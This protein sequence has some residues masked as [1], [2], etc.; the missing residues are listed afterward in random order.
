MKSGLAALLALAAGSLHAASTT[1][2]E[3][4]SYQDFVHGKFSGVSLDR[5]GTLS[6]APAVSSLFSSGQAV[7][8]SLAAGPN[9]V[10]YAGTGHGGIVYQISPAGQAKVLWKADQPEVFALAVNP[11]GVL[12]AATSPDGKVFR[13]EGGKAAEFFDPHAKYIWSLCFAPDGTL[14]VGTGGQGEIFRVDPLGHGEKYYSTG[15]SHVTALA[16]DSQGRLLAGSE[17]NGILYRILAKDKA[18]VLFDSPLPEIRALAQGP[19]GSIYAAAMGGS[20]SNRLGVQTPTALGATT[21]GSTPSVSVTV[22]DSAAAE[23]DGQA[24]PELKPKP[25]APAAATTAVRP[26]LNALSPIVELSGVDKSAVYRILPDNTV[27][28]LWTSKDENVYDMDLSG[29]DIL[30]ATDLQGRLYR[31]GA[32]RKNALIAETGEGEIVKLL[33][34]PA[35]LVAATADMGKIFRIGS[36]PAASGSYEAPVHDTGTVARWGRLTW[37]SSDGVGTIRFETRSGNSARPDAT[38]SDWAGAPDGALSSPN[39]RFIQW[40]VFLAR[41]ASLDGV[42]LAYLPQNTPPV[43]RSIVVSSAG[44]GSSAAAKS[45]SSSSSANASYSITV[46]DTGDAPSLSSGTPS[47]TVG[48]SGGGQIQITWQ[49]DDPDSDKLAYSV[50]FRGEE[51]H[52]W[53]L[54]KANLSENAYTVDGDSLADGRYFFRVVASDR[55]SNPPGQAREAD[56]VSSPVLVDNTPPMVRITSSRRD[57][58][59]ASIDV[60][61]ADASSPLRRCEYSVDAGPWTMVEATDGIT[62]SARE[63]F[64][65]RASNLEMGEHLVVVRVY[66]I[67]GNAGLAK[68]VLK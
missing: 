32:D 23:G 9:G 47:Q 52:A 37:R 45:Q 42:T 59:N 62:D 44:P 64:Q 58:G 68:T 35:G 50:Y 60:E 29:P 61:A 4:N 8:W 49:A 21:A 28:T 48:R 40:R 13:I 51:E 26:V 2:W 1:T 12:Y 7:V 36:A 11:S 5:A 14:Y 30:L 65:I 53:K 67:A 57:G 63:Q 55:P 25:G 24:A 18:F 19:D 54:L 66:D 17:P 34:S 10:L 33:P 3:M 56:L 38:W 39:A 31:L 15:Q 20:V 46:T 6:I 27:E 41:G 22:T 43:V 16:T